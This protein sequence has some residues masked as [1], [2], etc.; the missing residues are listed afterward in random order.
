MSVDLDDLPA[1]PPTAGRDGVALA[2]EAVV[3]EYPGGVRA[4]AGVSV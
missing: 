2:L 3:K 1:Q 4:L